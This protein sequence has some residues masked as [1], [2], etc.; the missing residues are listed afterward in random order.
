MRT[1]TDFEIMNPFL[2]IRN[3]SLEV[4][5][6]LSKITELI[7]EVAGTQVLTPHNRE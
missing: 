1:T 2:Q 7:R 5:N 4:L 6:T 3:F